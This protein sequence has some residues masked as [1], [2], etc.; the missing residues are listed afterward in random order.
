MSDNTLNAAPAQRTQ[1]RKTLTLVP[2]VMMG[3]AYLQPM[4]IFDTFGI[5]SGLTDGHVATAYAFALLAI[6][7]TA[8]SYGKLVKKFPSAG[9]AYTYAQKAISPHVGFMVG[10][11]SLLDY[12]F[13]PMINILLAKIYLEA[14][15]PGVPS[16]I[17]VAVLVGLMTIFNLRGIKLVANLNSIIV[18]VQV[19]IMIVFL[20]L[21]INGIY[22]GEGA[23]TLVS[24]R[25]FWSDNAHVV[26]MITGATILCFVPGLRRHQLAV[27]RDQRRRESDP[28]SHLPDGADRRHHLYRGVLLRAAVLPGH[29]AL[30]GS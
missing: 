3:L 28:E 5:V 9:S 11:S 18:V 26:P 25:P 4:T 14:I 1:L 29:L 19:A 17:F 21:V 20:G 12:L 7:F 6:L 16:W 27:R 15:F 10:W 30:Q 8:L 2:V 23:G 22:H 24:S 13:M